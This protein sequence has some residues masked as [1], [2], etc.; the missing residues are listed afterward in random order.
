[1]LDPAACAGMALGAPRVSISALAE[2][3]HLL[4]ERGFRRSSS[5]H[6]TIVR[7]KQHEKSAASAAAKRS[8]AP[9]QHP[10]RFRKAPGDQPVGPTHGIGPADPPSVGGRRRRGAGA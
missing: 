9:T 5:D 2:L 1:M 6:P 10:I 3:H 4:I 8:A 7:E